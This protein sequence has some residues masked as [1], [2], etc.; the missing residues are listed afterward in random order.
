MQYFFNE[1]TS[2]WLEEN[3][4]QYESICAFSDCAFLG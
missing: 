1:Y 3:K 4:A 2:Y